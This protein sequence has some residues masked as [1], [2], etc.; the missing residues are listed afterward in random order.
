MGFKVKHPPADEHVEVWL[1]TGDE[2]E[3]TVCLNGND[4]NDYY[5][6]TLKAD[7]TLELADVAGL[8]DSLT[9]EKSGH[10]KV[11]KE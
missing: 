7:G 4:G 8:V 10:I 2:G 3:V 6:L 9:L 1:E 5:F 11:T